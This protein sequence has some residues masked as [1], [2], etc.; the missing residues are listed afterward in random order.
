MPPVDRSTLPEAA[1]NLRL[2]RLSSGAL[3]LLNRNN[4]LVQPR[5]ASPK[6]TTTSIAA[7]T[8]PVTL[9]L[10]IG[11]NIRLGDDPP[12]LPAGMT[13]QA[14]PHIARSVTNDDF[15][16]AT[17]QEGRFTDGGAVDV[18]YSVSHDGGL[19]WSRALL[20]NLT[21]AFNGPY[22]RATDPVVSYDLSGNIYISTDA[23]TENNFNNGAIVVSKSADGGNTFNAP[24]TVYR[25]PNNNNFPDKEWLAVN[26]FSGTSTVGRVIVTFTLFSNTTNNL[27][28][29]YRSYSDNGGTSWSSI[30]NVT[31]AGSSV[32]G[33]QP[34]YLP[35][36]NCV[37][38]YWNF[39]TNT[40]PGERLEAIIST[41]GGNTFG[42]PFLIAH[43]TEWNE[44]NI[45]SGGFLP[46]AAIDRI[47]GAIHVV[48]QT[49]LNGS[50]RIAY[51]KSTD[52]GVSWTTPIAISDNPA[53]LGVFNPAIAVAPGGRTLSAV[54]YDHRD[55][56]AS[57]TLVNM[58]LAQS[59]DGGA[60]WQP[61]IRLSSVTTDATL[62]PLTSGGYMLGDYLGVANSTLQTVPAIPV[63]V[64]TRTGDPDPFITRAGIAPTEEFGPAWEAAHSSLANIPASS[65]RSESSDLDRDGE[66]AAAEAATGTDPT[67][68]ASVTRTAR[69]LNISTRLHVG[70]N[71][72]VGI[73]GFIITGSSSKSILIRALGPSLA[74]FNVPDILQDPTLE[75]YDAN[76]TLIASNNNWKDSQQAQIQA[77]GRAPGDDREAAI[78]QTL[79]PGNYTAIVRGNANTTGSA[80]VEVYDLDSTDASVLGNIS[81]RAFVDTGE[82]VPIGGFIVGGGQGTNGDGSSQVLIRGIG[83]ELANFNVSNPLQDPT[84][85]LYDANG[86]QIATN[87]NWKDKQ[88]AAIVATGRAPSDDRE[89]AILA[90]LIQGNW[91]TIMRGKNGTTGIG[92]IEVYRNQ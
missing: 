25:P 17:F 74:P 80:L 70:T 5:A 28:P 35:N 90:T 85:E 82:F 19:T 88:Q 81:T 63:W 11:P 38:V 84:L 4:N 49:V 7:E 54:F 78:L 37:I 14:E 92:L 67:N 30:T 55:N 36:G 58:Y 51:T 60:T 32:Q 72:N 64:D 83:P 20:P 62:A 59:F 53:G 61:N 18:G 40:A 8:L 9:D 2:E 73:A 41:N 56:A 52:G 39:G 66:D 79:A 27:N 13:A 47:T 10:R 22:F 21:M 46:A 91:T 3:M 48:Y 43:A 15:L 45:R 44:P 89:P 42:A 12:Q 71:E 69:E 33:S 86:N 87:D 57:Q 76:N 1:R 31:G 34:V 26:T 29:I 50:P 77:T 6:G 23:A 16:T 68:Y 75:L 24:V 65:L